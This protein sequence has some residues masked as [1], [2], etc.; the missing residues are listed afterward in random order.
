MIQNS[1]YND[2]DPWFVDF[3]PTYHNPHKIP[4]TEMQKYHKLSEKVDKLKDQLEEMKEKGQDVQDKELE[5][6]LSENKL[7]EG[8]FKMANM[9]VDSLKDELDME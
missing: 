5:L 3:R 7:K 9:Y 4:D 6:Q 1:N 2:G 8:R